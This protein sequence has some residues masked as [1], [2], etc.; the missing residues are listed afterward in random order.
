M[1]GRKHMDN[2]VWSNLFAF[3]YVCVGPNCMFRNSGLVQPNVA[4]GTTSCLPHGGNAA[5][6]RC[7]TES[8]AGARGR[9]G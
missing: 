1:L 9:G 5:P 6:A 8:G 7:I 3:Q 4:P 2:T